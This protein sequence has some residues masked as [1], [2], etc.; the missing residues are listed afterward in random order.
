MLT[1]ASQPDGGDQENG[2]RTVLGLSH[3]GEMD[4]VAAA[5]LRTDGVLVVEQGPAAF[6][7]YSRAVK[8]FLRRARKAV[9]EGRRGAQDVR[10]AERA[11]T[12]TFIEAASNLLSEVAEAGDRKIDLVGYEGPD[13][14]GSEIVIRGLQG[15]TR[16]CDA[17]RLAREI[18]VSCV[19]SFDAADV[20]AG[21]AGGDLA[22]TF[23]AALAMRSPQLRAPCA[24]LDV[25]DAAHLTFPPQTEADAPI[26]FD[27]GP[28]L[29]LVDSWMRIKTGEPVD[30]DGKAAKAG[31][32]DE[33]TLALM[34]TNPYL[35]RGAP[36]RLRPDDFR[37]APVNSLSIFDGAA[38]LTAFAA[39]CAARSVDLLP[40]T[41]GAWIVCGRGRRNPALMAELSGRLSG[42]VGR[43]E[44]FGLRGD[45]L[46][47]E[48]AAFL[49]V[50]SARRLPIS[51]P[52]TTGAPHALTGGKVVLAS[53]GAVLGQ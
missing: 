7:P 39:A 23:L 31:R 22:E 19:G 10:D 33:E 25:A 12:S 45:F 43:L 40:S 30:R 48:R 46:D 13:I 53:A 44:D 32:V 4:G 11:V 41:P 52:K 27:C 38:T 24:I 49:A 3:R 5:I 18:G 34:L 14:D 35:K 37:I 42:R 21:G 20:A 9:A 28:G 17:A 1:R 36:K 26:S 51:F 16:L 47:A 2:V 29:A 8:T 6:V 50:R 15:R